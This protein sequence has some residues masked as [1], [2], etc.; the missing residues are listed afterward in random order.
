MPGYKP[1]NDPAANPAQF[2]KSLGAKIH[3][4]PA[5]C[6]RDGRCQSPGCDPLP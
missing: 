1:C 2:T 4:T 6:R 3:T 5:G